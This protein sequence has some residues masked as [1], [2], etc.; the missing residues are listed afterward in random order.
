MKIG[1]A[2]AAIWL[3]F[4]VLMARMVTQGSG[5]RCT[6]T[7][8]AALVRLM[9]C[10][11][12]VA[13]YGPMPPTLACCNALRTLGRPCLCVIVNGP[14][15]SGID[16]NLALELPSKCVMYLVETDHVAWEFRKQHPI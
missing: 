12:A 15:I 5:Q 14:P 7:F 6:L 10:R 1:S 16:R 8:F 9:P 11:A 13:P 3:I 2:K 4:L